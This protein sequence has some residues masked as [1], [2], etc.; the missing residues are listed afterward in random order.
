[1]GR[2]TWG[3]RGGEEDVGRKTWGGRRG[4]EDV[5]RKTW[6]GRRGEEEED[7]GIKT[8]SQAAEGVCL[9]LLLCDS[10]CS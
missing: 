3:G 7:K 8:V 2:K 6:G 4:E 10:Q 1:M 9:T 5:E